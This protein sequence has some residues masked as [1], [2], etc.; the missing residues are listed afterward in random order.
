[1]Y[2]ING[3]SLIHNRTHSLFFIWFHL[4]S[5]IIKEKKK[6]ILWSHLILEYLFNS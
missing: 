6:V 5:S 4:L 1:M 3:Q 2:Q